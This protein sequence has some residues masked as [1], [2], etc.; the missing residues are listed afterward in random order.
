MGDP[1]KDKKLYT[2]RS[3]FFHVDKIQIP[4]QIYQAENDVRTVKAE[5]DTFV[6]ELRKKGKPVEYTVLKD[7][8][9]GLERPE[10]RKQIMEGT[11]KFFKSMIR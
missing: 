7:V 1:V 6:A 5:M 2:D 3:P 9:H 4:L 11:V 8:G 10:S